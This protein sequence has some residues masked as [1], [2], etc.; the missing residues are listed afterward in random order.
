M[1]KF[2][3]FAILSGFFFFLAAVLI[4]SCGDNNSTNS[5]SF[6]PPGV[7]DGIYRVIR[8]WN[9][10]NAITVTNTVTFNF[11]SDKTFTMR[12]DDSTYPIPDSR[13]C[14]V[15]GN[16][17]FRYDT[18]NLTL[19]NDNVYMDVCLLEYGPEGKFHYFESGGYFL[20]EIRAST[21]R[22]I[23]FLAR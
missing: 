13:F 9:E 21:Y 11:K 18:L 2:L 20:F 14:D 12:V 3:T 15:N 1:R 6:N 10:D 8:N 7:Y 4:F 23:E 16:W 5:V 22:R 17:E 19:T